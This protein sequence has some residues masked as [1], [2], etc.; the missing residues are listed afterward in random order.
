MF[1]LD[2]EPARARR[3]RPIAA[4][5]LLG[6]VLHGGALAAMGT[7]ENSA[8]SQP[9]RTERIQ[10]RLNVQPQLV[11]IPS[12]PEP[13]PQ[14]QPPPKAEVPSSQRP[15]SQP[16]KPVE[17]EL[18]APDVSTSPPPLIVGL[19]LSSTTAQG[20]AGRYAIG[21]TALGTPDRVA[22]TLMPQPL[23]QPALAP[24]TETRARGATSKTATEAKMLRAVS[25]VYPAQAK[26]EGIEG[27]VVVAVTI[28]AA[29]NVESVTVLRGLGFGLDESAMRAVRETAWTPGSL[30]G[31]AVRTTRR[32]NIRFSLQS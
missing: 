15:K 25:P 4:A 19:T 32:L 31:R 21:N 13:P 17:H 7:L 5:T 24:A 1:A 27:V 26:R 28:D 22:K 30:D 9:P 6:A 18:P 8:L 14:P 12:P 16:I 20:N 11:T 3:L 2:P 10:M 29:G 23:V